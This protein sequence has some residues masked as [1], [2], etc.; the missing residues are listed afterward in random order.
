MLSAMPA[1]ADTQLSKAAYEGELTLV[2]ERVK[3]GV[4]VNDIDKWGWTALTWAVYYNH[5]AIVKWLLENGADPDFRTVRA[6]GD[7]H[8]GTTVT[9]LA[10]YY[11]YEEILKELLEHH[12]D[13]T[14]TDVHGKTALDYAKKFNFNA[15]VVLLQ[16]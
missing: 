7:F 12:A 1:F 14:V 4:N 2:Q 15:C 6:Y 5:P 3:A 8:P 9:I 11:G 16:R 10:G 13:I